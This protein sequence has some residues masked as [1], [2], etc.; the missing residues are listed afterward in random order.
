MVPD[1]KA[2]AEQFGEGPDADHGKCEDC[3]NFYMED[4]KRCC[5][6]ELLKEEDGEI[7]ASKY[8]SKDIVCCGAFEKKGAIIHDK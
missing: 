1:S 8:L 7:F 2:C 6:F 3:I 5:T 4:N